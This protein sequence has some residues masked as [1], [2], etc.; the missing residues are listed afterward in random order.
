MMRVGIYLI[1]LGIFI[2]VLGEITFPLNTTLNVNNSSMYIIPPWYEKA[3]VSVNSG[4]FLIVYHNYTYILLVKGSITIK[5]ASILYGVGNASILLEGYKI[6]YNQS[7]IAVGIFL[8]IVGVGL[9]IIR[10]KRRKD[11]QF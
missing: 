3:K 2:L 9:E 11:H 1:S 6:F 4:S 10:F 5:P 8:I 7:Y